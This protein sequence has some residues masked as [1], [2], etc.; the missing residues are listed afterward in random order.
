MSILKVN[1]IED[2]NG[3]P[4][5]PLSGVMA[6]ARV[7]GLT[8]GGTNRLLSGSNVSTVTRTGV[9]RYTVS[10]TTSLP[11]NNYAAITTAELVGGGTLQSAYTITVTSRSTS[12]IDIGTT[13][14]LGVQNQP[15]D[16][17]NF[18]LVVIGLI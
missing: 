6:W 8:T 16:N 14:D 10:F 15:V 2:L 18:S 11:N 3:D 7:N 12:T 1:D 13:Y 17:V 9:G 5:V 4:L